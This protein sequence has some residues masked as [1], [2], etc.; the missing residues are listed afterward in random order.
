MDKSRF[1]SVFLSLV[2]LLALLLA[3]VACTDPEKVERARAAR[4]DAEA[5]A[6]AAPIVAEG[7]AQVTVI[8]ALTNA[9]LLKLR[10]ETDLTKEM[11]QF[12]ASLARQEYATAILEMQALME[13]LRENQVAVTSLT[14]QITEVGEVPE[15]AR[16]AASNS[17]WAL[18]AIPISSLI[19]ILSFIAV[20]GMAIS[21]VTKS[22]R[23]VA[24]RLEAVEDNLPKRAKIERKGQ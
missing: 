2:V 11:R 18:M 8:E 17:W 7:R 24:G 19:V 9:E 22:L 15:D 1:V 13:A 16:A 21:N 12:D 14:G 10:T 23:Q 5:R 6:K 4:H 3:V 20:G